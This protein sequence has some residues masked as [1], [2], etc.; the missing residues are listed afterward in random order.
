[1]IWLFQLLGLC[2]QKE[3]PV[4]ILEALNGSLFDFFK[5]DSLINSKVA[6]SMALDICSGKKNVSS[7]YH[8][9]IVGMSHLHEE[10]LLHCDLAARNLLVM[11]QGNNFVIKIGDLGMAEIISNSENITKG[12]S[13]NSNHLTQFS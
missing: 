5:D 3:H 9:P 11:I 8:W 4:I 2:S 6:L 1:L 13:F 10:N 12:I 7:I